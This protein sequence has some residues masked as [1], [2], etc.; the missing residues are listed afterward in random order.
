MPKIK[1]LA[2]PTITQG[3]QMLPD[4]TF[5]KVIF[6]KKIT[7]VKKEVQTLD[8]SGQVLDCRIETCDEAEA[9]EPT[10][11]A[12][13]AP[14]TPSESISMQSLVAERLGLNPEAP[15]PI[16]MALISTM[17]TVA[18]VFCYVVFWL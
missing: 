5:Q 6:Y 17:L 13:A 10:V 7:L 9:T 14:K 16:R 4:T 18:C 8:E 3:P 11:M 15:D 1:K 12:L 2:I